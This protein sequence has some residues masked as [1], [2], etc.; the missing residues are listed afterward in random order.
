MNPMQDRAMLA[1]AERLA[2]TA[3]RWDARLRSP[4]CT[5]QDRRNFAAWRDADPSHQAAFERL[6]S[7]IVGLRQERSRA[8]LRAIRDSALGAVSKRRVRRNFGMAAAVAAGVVL[9]ATWLLV[10]GRGSG[11]QIY[12]TSAGQRSTVELQDGSVL[13]LSSATRVE[14]AFSDARRSVRLHAGQAIFKVARQQERPFVVRAGD[15]EIVAL[16]TMFD[17]RLERSALR[18]TLLE[19]RVSVNRDGTDDAHGASDAQSEAVVLQPGQQAVVTQPSRSDAIL[20]SSVEAHVHVRAIDVA[21]VTAWLDGRVFLEDTPLVDAVA[22]M[23]RH[24]VTRILVT[25]AQLLNLRVNGMFIAGEQQAFATALAEYFPIA[26]ERRGE[27]E[28]L[29]RPRH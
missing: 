18:V 9:A 5:D 22:E 25:D 24:S 3:G 6:Q 8:D 2:R 13:E 19:G 26:M 11:A 29:L 23:N 27:R 20:P 7:I 16:G 14:V 12:S 28:I 1:A 4:Q 10:A 21:K 17:V 15:Q